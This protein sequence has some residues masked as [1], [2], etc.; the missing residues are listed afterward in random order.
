MAL[1]YSLPVRGS[2]SSLSLCVCM[3]VCF[4]SLLSAI[5]WRSICMLY[6]SI[7]H[8]TVINAVHQYKC[9]S[10]LEQCLIRCWTRCRNFCNLVTESFQIFYE[11]IEQ[12]CMFRNLED[13]Q[14]I[15]IKN[16]LYSS[17]D[18]ALLNNVIHAFNCIIIW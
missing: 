7:V 14:W 11:I 16:V 8:F 2:W 13:A 6:T 5:I 3:Y 18:T 10:W 1:I 17:R 12:S 9:I 15:W 4:I